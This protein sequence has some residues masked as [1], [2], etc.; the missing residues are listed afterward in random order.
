MQVDG[1]GNMNGKTLVLLPG[2]ACDDQI[3]VKK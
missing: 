3:S 1:M 2:T